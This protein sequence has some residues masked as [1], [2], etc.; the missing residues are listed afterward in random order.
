MCFS[1]SLSF[2]L[3][4]AGRFSSIINVVQLS[5]PGGRDPTG[6]L[7]LSFGL[8]LDGGNFRA[9]DLVHVLEYFVH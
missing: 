3:G 7:G 8:R 5:F 6:L 4:F 1:T 9:V 2:V